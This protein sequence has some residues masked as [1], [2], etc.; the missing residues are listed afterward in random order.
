MT[1]YWIIDLYINSNS[2]YQTNDKFYNVNLIGQISKY[3]FFMDLIN[4]TWGLIF[5]VIVVKYENS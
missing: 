1:I 3:S 5:S 2:F 4:W